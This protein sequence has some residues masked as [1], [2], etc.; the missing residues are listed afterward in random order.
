MPDTGHPPPP[1]RLRGQFLLIPTG[2]GTGVML[3]RYTGGTL[4][5]HELI[6][7]GRPFVVQTASRRRLESSRDG[8]AESC[9]GS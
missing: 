5:Y 3:A 1:W 6:V 7:F 8:A 9:T 2:F 4:A